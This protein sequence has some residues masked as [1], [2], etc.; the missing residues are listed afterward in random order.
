[1]TGAS[2]T[3]LPWVRQGVA[4]AITTPDTL[5][6]KQP[7]VVDLNATVT[8]NASPTPAVPPP[9]R[10]RLR[11][12]ADV[13]GIDA[14]Q[15]VRTDPRPGS[16]RLRAELF[17]LRRVRSPRFSVAVHAGQRRRQREAAAV[18]VPGGRA[19]AGRRDARQHAQFAAA[20]AADRRTRE[21]GD[22]LP[23]LAEC[24][25][26]VH[27]Q[28]AG[29]DSTEGAVRAALN[30]S[31]E[32]SLS[33]LIC[34]RMLAPNTD[35]IA[36]VVPTFELGRKAGLGI[37]IQDTEL[38]A[39]TALAPAW[40][41]PRR[42]PSAA[43]VVLPVYHHWEF[44]TG[45][46]GDFA[47]LA[48][49]S[50]A[51]AGA[52]GARAPADRHQ[53][54]R[55]RPAARLSRRPTLEVEGALRPILPTGAPDVMPPWSD[56]HPAVPDALAAIVNAPGAAASCR[57]GADPLLAPPLYGRW[58]RGRAPSRPPAHRPSGSISSTSIRACAASRRSA[59][60]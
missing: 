37:A 11:G 44:R 45:V 53:H 17:S 51:A 56:R 24:W 12:P 57:P 39:A 27:A 59:R 43:P 42:R 54:A 8:V 55:L 14:N 4:A 47:S 19:Q 46:G 7:A 41:L 1:M 6:A 38:V 10:V 35:Y 26:W 23:D 2:L 36:C 13:V 58:L 33:R 15:I 9:C 20:G 22:E 28:A 52:R 18:A 25:A 16:D 49:R 48:A 5:G 29:A 60:A 50:A 21:A 31:P 40:S 3:F 34:P 32:L 30:G